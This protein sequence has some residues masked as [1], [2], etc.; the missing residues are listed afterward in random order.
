MRFR[1]QATRRLLAVIESTV[2]REICFVL[3]TDRELTVAEIAVRIGRRPD[4]LYH[5]LKALQRVGLVTTKGTKIEGGRPAKLWCMAQG[6]LYFKSST[7]D[8]VA[9]R[10]LVRQANTDL[11]TALTSP[12][13]ITERIDAAYLMGEFTFFNNRLR[14]VTGV[15]FERTTDDGRAVDVN[16]TPGGIEMHCALSSKRTE[17]MTHILSSY[18]MRE[19]PVLADLLE[20]FVIAVDSFVAEH[21]PADQQTAGQQPG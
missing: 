19:L 7:K 21:Q 13:R 6:F 1:Q 11:R 16:I 10:A 4:A 20:R 5:H 12:Q 14:V 8:P 3:E 2:R 9:R 17:L 15:R 18:R